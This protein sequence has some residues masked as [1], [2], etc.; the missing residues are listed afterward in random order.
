MRPRTTVLL[1]LVF[2][3]LLSL[4]CNLL[5]PAAPIIPERCLTGLNDLHLGQ[6]RNMGNQWMAT[7]SD[8]K[9]V[10]PLMEEQCDYFLAA[11]GK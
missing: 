1:A 8:A 7:W 10:Q 11:E 9:V 3:V 6:L 4:A 5:I 2:F